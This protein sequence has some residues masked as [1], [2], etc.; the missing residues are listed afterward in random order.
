MSNNKLQ[1]QSNIH[2]GL[3]KN[4]VQKWNWWT[5]KSSVWSNLGIRGMKAAKHS[6]IWLCKSQ[7]DPV[8]AFIQDKVIEEKNPNQQ[9]TELIDWR[10]GHILKNY[11][12][13]KDIEKMGGK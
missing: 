9:I 11:E 8:L 2:T 7:E 5:A 12:I 10:K 3:L 13:G 6:T 1:W 4:M